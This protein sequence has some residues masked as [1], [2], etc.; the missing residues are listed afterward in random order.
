MSWFFELIGDLGYLSKKFKGA[1]VKVRFHEETKSIV[2]NVYKNNQNIL[3]AM[4][5]AEDYNEIKA[6]VKN[7][8]ELLVRYG[9][10]KF[11]KSNNEKD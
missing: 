6:V 7:V 4:I 3:S 2:V 10:G 9:Y 1:E 8:L 5:T 11:I